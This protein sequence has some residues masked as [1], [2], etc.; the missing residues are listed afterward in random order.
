[1]ATLCGERLY[2]KP[3]R[4]ELGLG[5]GTATATGTGNGTS[6]G[7]IFESAPFPDYYRVGG[8]RGDF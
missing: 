6:T 5:T 4:A 2:L 3:T 1:M 7:I 8:G